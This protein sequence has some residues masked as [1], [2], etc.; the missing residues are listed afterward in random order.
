MERA[1]RAR[2]HDDAAHRH[3]GDVPDRAHPSGDRGAGGR[4]DGEHGAGRFFLG[5]GS[6][7][8][9]NEHV[10]GD[11]WP[12][13]DVRLDM[14][15]EAVDV[16][17][18]LWTGRQYSH[19]GPHYTV[20]NARIYTLPDDHPGHR[21]GVRAE[22]GASSRPRSATD[23]SATSPDRGAARAYTRAGG[24]GPKL[25]LMKVCW[26][27]DEARAPQARARPVADRR[28]ARRAQPGAA[29]PRPLRTGGGTGQI[30]DVADA[31]SC[32]PDPEVHLASIRQYAD[33]GYDEVY[34]QQI[35]ADQEG[36]FRFW[37][38]EV[39]PRI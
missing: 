29:D 31:I 34:V 2:G 33:A 10:L 18:G 19:H 28:R 38:D 8:A 9:L 27:E 35:G 1:R 21:L 37:S 23:T 24:S 7:E 39:A 6:G 26:G 15:R 13:T 4:D 16:M 12:E 22:G 36:F 3:V 17:R 25:A 32:G 30:D 14:L 11:R 20:E 5:V